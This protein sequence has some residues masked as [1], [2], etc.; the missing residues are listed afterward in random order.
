MASLTAGVLIKLLQNIDSKVKVRGEYRSVLLQVI[1]IVPALSGG[2]LWPDHG[3]F[4]KVSDSSHST[5]VSLSKADIELILNNKL[6]LGQF[7]YVDRLE[8]GNPVP[9]LVGVRPLPGRNPFIGNPKDLM[10]ILD[11]S[12][13]PISVDSHNVSNGCNSRAIKVSETKVKSSRVHKFVIKE[14]KSVVSSRYMEGVLS[15]HHRVSSTDSINVKSSDTESIGNIKVVT[16]K[17]K[18]HEPKGQSL[19]VTPCNSR[20]V[21]PSRP[22]PTT[23][24]RL[25]NT[26]PSRTRPVTPTR[27]RPDTF[28][29]KVESTREA[30]QT[31]KITTR[32]SITKQ[33]NINLNCSTNSKDKTQTQSSEPASPWNSLPTSLLKPGKVMLKSRDLASLVAVEAQKEAT[34]AAILVK[35][36]DMFADLC[37]SASPTSPHIALSKFFALYQVIDQPSS[38]KEKLQLLQTNDKPST[39]P[40]PPLNGKNMTRSPSKPPQPAEQLLSLADR[41]EWSKGH[42]TNDIKDVREMLLHET[43]S[44][45]LKFLDAALDTG[46]RVDK[47]IGKDHIGRKS[48][49]PNNHI[50]VTLSQLKQAN[51]WL[52]KLKGSVHNISAQSKDYGVL[53]RVD[54]L[55]KKVYACLLVHIDS[56]ASALESRSDRKS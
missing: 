35:C 46:F 33:E 54:K 1:S 2:E 17:S 12:E 21:S 7:F 48:L 29:A 24:S 43:R 15:T 50:A 38:S 39:R 36:I 25:R 34:A 49:E 47:K 51:E 16:S 13:G 40:P 41:F 4:L 11:P 20:P 27:T 37:S 26:V 23:P 3:F 30:L 42:G 9:T 6:Q 45:F 10:Q 53:E 19:P 55:K 14:E 5:Y 31:L 18:L 28:P 56:A 8:A 44:W 52:D 32:K 22:R